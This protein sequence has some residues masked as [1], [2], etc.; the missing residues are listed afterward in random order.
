MIQHIL[1]PTNFLDYAI[2][3]GHYAV[4][5]AA[6]HNARVTLFH[7]YHIPV[8]DPLVPSAYLS[9]L[10]STAERNAERSITQQAADLRET[11]PEMA[12]QIYHHIS[13]GF[14]ADEIL[15]MAERVGVDA[16]IVGTRHTDKVQRILLGSV[17]GTVL[18]KAAVPVIVVPD[19]VTFQ[20]V[21]NILFASEFNDSEDI[22][23]INQVLEFTSRLKA[24]L[25][26]V[27]IQ[28]TDPDENDMARIQNIRALYEGKMGEGKVHFEN[29]AYS[30]IIEGL[31]KYS[32][33]NDIDMAVM[34]TH[35]RSFF[36]KLFDRSLTKQMA[37]KTDIPLVVFHK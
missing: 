20:P 35:K 22:E 29:I 5:F 2:N 16:L 37:H 15:S 9:E 7:T 30:N 12:D 13:M 27:H 6:Q 28:D 32:Q 26:S 11:Y 25:Y 31:S 23:S 33:V 4:Q 24:I 36:E 10:A 17:L 3:A 19:H 8:V 14:A 18:E 21:K 1:V 34:V